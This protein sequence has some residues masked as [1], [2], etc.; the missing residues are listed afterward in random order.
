MVQSGWDGESS[1]FLDAQQ[2]VVLVV[3]MPLDLVM[4]VYSVVLVTSS[5]SVVVKMRSDSVVA[6]VRSDSVVAVV[7]KLRATVVDGSR[8]FPI[9]FR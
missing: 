9:Y 1:T 8:S 2:V 7:A 4:V 6:V 3:V 5:N